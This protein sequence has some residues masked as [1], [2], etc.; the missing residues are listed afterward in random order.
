[1]GDGMGRCT[2][3]V[4]LTGGVGSLAGLSKIVRHFSSGEGRIPCSKNFFRLHVKF[5]KIIQD[6]PFLVKMYN[7]LFCFLGS[8]Q[9]TWFLFGKV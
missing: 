3:K 7:V 2:Y 4:N 9:E 1:M 5:M 8:L 6:K